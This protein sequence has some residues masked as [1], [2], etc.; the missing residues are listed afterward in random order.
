MM[1]SRISRYCTGYMYS[2]SSIVERP[3]RPR[4]GLM[5]QQHVC[6]VL[7]ITMHSEHAIDLAKWSC[8]H[9]SSKIIRYILTIALLLKHRKQMSWFQRGSF[10][11]NTPPTLPPALTSI[12][13]VM[14]TPPSQLV[15]ITEENASR[16]S[17]V[18]TTHATRPICNHSAHS[19]WLALRKAINEQSWHT[20]KA[21]HDGLLSKNHLLPCT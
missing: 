15:G 1:F 3:S 19:L 5:S 12:S 21:L 7:Q 16:S 4:W 18:H 2:I 13:E 9:H 14:V 6:I 17:I 10:I 8:S 11:N 20:I